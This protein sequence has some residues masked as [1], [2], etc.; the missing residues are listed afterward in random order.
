MTTADPYVCEHCDDSV[1]HQHVDERPLVESYRRDLLRAVLAACAVS[2]VWLALG[3]TTAWG[4]V[5]GVILGMAAWAVATAVGVLFFLL[6]RRGKPA[7][8]AVIGGAIATAAVSPILAL[9]VAFLTPG[10][11]AARAVVAGL[12]WLVL[13]TLVT[14][15]RAGRLRAQLV[16]HTRDGEAARSAVVRTGGRPSPYVEAGWLVGTAVVFGL[17]VAATAALPVVT[18]VLVP[19]NAAL[20]VLSRR[21]QARAAQPQAASS[22]R[23]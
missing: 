9:L 21:L 12:G 19:L 11:I 10:P 14:A 20:A 1:P 15:V 22:T 13:S 23:R 2:V 5:L 17:C 4:S 18:G 7:A 16:A 6:T 3:L 8:T